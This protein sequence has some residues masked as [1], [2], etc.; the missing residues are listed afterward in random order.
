[1][2]CRHCGCSVVEG[3]ILCPNCGMKIESQQ[4]PPVPNI[5]VDDRILEEIPVV[6]VV[7]EDSREQVMYLEPEPEEERLMPDE[8]EQSFSKPDKKFLS[9]RS[10]RLVVLVSAA[11]VVL[12]TLCLLGPF[13]GWLVRTFTAPEKLLVKVY[14]NCAE[15]ALSLGENFLKTSGSTLSPTAYAGRIDVKIGEHILNLVTGSLGLEQG[16]LSWL[17]AIDLSYQSETAEGMI[18]Q[19]LDLGLDNTN[20]LSSQYIYEKETGKKWLLFPKL[21]DKALLIPPEETAISGYPVN[22]YRQMLE[23]Q[24]ID[25]SVA[26]ELTDRYLPILLSG[27]SEVRLS[28]QYVTADNIR[29]KVW[30]LN[31]YGTEEDLVRMTIRLLETV[32]QDLQIRGILDDYSAAYNDYMSKQQPDWNPVDLY[33]VF[34]DRV[35]QELEVCRGRVGFSDGD[36]ILTLQTYLGSNNHM[37][38]FRLSSQQEEL[39]LLTLTQGNRFGVQLHLADIWLS[40]G[41]TVGLQSQ[42]EFV[43]SG[44]AGEL[45]FIQLQDISLTD[46]KLTGK[47][48]IE[49]SAVA[50]QALVQHTLD[51]AATAAM[52]S[53]A[54]MT[55]QI[56]L[57][58]QSQ[59]VSFFSNRIPILSVAFTTTEP[60]PMSL[61]KPVDWVDC[62]DEAALQQWIASVNFFKLIQ[63]LVDAGAPLEGLLSFIMMGN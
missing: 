51:D 47:I 1:M 61:Q 49:P 7:D 2:N 46:R 55:I 48:E 62:N 56:D 39:S 58:Q 42:G 24:L 52:L 5:K 41:G 36:H 57:M 44:D 8:L 40:G 23:N 35:A 16:S 4:E 10:A 32:Q 30:V 9:K 63:D 11:V 25:S 12:L 29:Q 21:Q 45:L 43:V 20:I 15:N 59:S 31:A 33:A 14:Q 22:F 18:Y 53:M 26:E 37:L 3:D 54:D 17:S 28:S 6:T 50:I 27:F 13:R 19:S 38:G 60:K 34:A